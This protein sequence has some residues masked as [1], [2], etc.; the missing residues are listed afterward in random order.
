M[1]TTVPAAPTVAHPPRSDA[2]RAM[3]RL[4]RLPVDGPKTSILGAEGAFQKSIAI[5][6]ARC[7]FTYVLLP[8]LRPLVDLSGGVG[9]VL[10]L[11]VGAV[12]MV[13]IAFS[14]RRF[15][16]ADHKYRWH[17]T[18]VGGGIFVLLVWQSVL[19]VQALL[20]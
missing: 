12:S 13:A 11:L 8:V 18:V 9:P 2:D 4:L 17:Y 7:L 5:S 3:R 15:F 1:D 16:A 20:A 10:G 6:A 19:D 14:V